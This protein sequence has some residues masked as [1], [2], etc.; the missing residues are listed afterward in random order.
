MSEAEKRAY[1]LADNRLAEEAGWNQEILAIELQCLIDMDFTVELTGFD[2]A[3]VDEIIEVQSKAANA[4]AGSQLTSGASRASN[5]L[6]C[7]AF[8]LRRA[9]ARSP[10]RALFADCT[11]SPSAS[12]A[13][14]RSRMSISPS[15]KGLPSNA[16]LK[17]AL[18]KLLFP[19]FFEP[20]YRTRFHAQ[21]HQSIS[22][23]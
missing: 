8:T 5:E 10:F 22:T 2:L 3:E 13:G 14:A 9:S 16:M 6:S 21:K 4:A 18:L 1:I 7:V 11:I 20:S 12:K 15:S 23:P 17:A 19:V